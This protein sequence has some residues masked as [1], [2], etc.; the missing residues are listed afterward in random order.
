MMHRGSRGSRARFLLVLSGLAAAGPVLAHE[1]DP[2][3]LAFIEFAPNRYEVHW[4]LAIPGG[5]P[6]VLEPDLP[7]SC[8]MLGRPEVR[9]D[10]ENRLV[11]GRLEC[12]G[13][14]IAQRIG[15]RGLSSTRTD[16][17]VRIDG[18][19]GRAFTARLTPGVPFIVVPHEADALTTAGTYLVLGVEHILR[20]AD[21]LLFVFTLLLYVRGVRRLVVTV[22]AFTVAH[23]ITLGAAALGVARLPQ[24]PV[25]ALIALS[26]VCVAAAL[27]RA[28]ALPHAGP[29]PRWP[30]LLAFVFGLLH[31]FG[32]AGALAELGLPERALVLAL[33]CFNVGVELGQLAFIAVVLLG[34]ALLGRWV[35]ALP[36]VWSR[37]AVYG[38][39]SVASF[40]VVERSA[41]LL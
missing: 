26:I 12:P 16:A 3:L 29:A 20:G 35:R 28:P 36:S 19:E 32:F 21:H 8:T 6:N 7:A 5:L 9:I 13:G 10:G 11:S 27:A 37:V 30:W 2:A 17:L 14:L 22:T 23:S 18:L 1:L 33:L 24:A 38:I 31:G 34:G 40:W 4:K 41:G 25:E 39:G 15:I